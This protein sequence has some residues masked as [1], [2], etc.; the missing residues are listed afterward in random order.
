MAA[1]GH[2]SPTSSRHR[3]CPSRV[4]ALAQWED[5]DS[6]ALGRLFEWCLQENLEL[7][8]GAHRVAD[9]LPNIILVECARITGAKGLQHEEPAS[10]SLS[11]KRIS[12]ACSKYI[13]E[14][15]HEQLTWPGS[16]M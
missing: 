11:V 10:S 15:F 3:L 4:D 7:R 1:C 9:S 16:R 6:R 2:A 5:L 12:A 8:A 13:D 14:H